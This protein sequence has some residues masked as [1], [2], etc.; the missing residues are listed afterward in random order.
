M[1]LGKT[2]LPSRH[3]TEFDAAIEI[4]FRYTVDAD[5]LA[6]EYHFKQ[7]QGTLIER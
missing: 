3:M 5:L 2:A 6:R 1:N 7:P 4:E